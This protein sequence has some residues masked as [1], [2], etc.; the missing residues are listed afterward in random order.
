MSFSNT[1]VAAM[2]PGSVP[3]W[4][5]S[6]TMS[7]R[8]SAVSRTGAALPAAAGLGSPATA[9]LRKVSRSTLRKGIETSTAPSRVLTVSI[10]STTA[11]PVRSTTMRERPG[12]N[13]P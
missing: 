7:G 2:A 9:A 4:P 13:R 5:A 6:M 10:A 11:G 12:A 3:P 8:V 1:P